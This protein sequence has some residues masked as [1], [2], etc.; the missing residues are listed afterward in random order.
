MNFSSQVRHPCKGFAKKTVKVKGEAESRYP[1]SPAK[2]AKKSVQTEA[3][4]PKSSAKVSGGR[5]TWP[6]VE[7]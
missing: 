5:P 7:G 2:V 3:E 6:L 1:K 4:Y